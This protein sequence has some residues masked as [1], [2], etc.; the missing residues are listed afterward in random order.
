MRGILIV[1]I[2]CQVGLKGEFLKIYTIEESE[3]VGWTA[4]TLDADPSIFTWYKVNLF[5]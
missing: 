1:L 4:L 3:K 5:C 2:C